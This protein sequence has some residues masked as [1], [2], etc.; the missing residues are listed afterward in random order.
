MTNDQIVQELK[1]RL[2]AEGASF[3]LRYEVSKN[4][5]PDGDWTQFYVRSDE[6][7]Q[8]RAASRQIIADVE[9]DVVKAA[10]REIILIRVSELVNAA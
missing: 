5:R 8:N 6:T 2:N 3:G 9:E 1:R 10:G 7:R 4:A